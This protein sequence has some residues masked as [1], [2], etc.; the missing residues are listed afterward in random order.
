MHAMIRDMSGAPEQPVRPRGGLLGVLPYLLDLIFPIVA[1]FV[2]KKLGASDFWALTAGGLLTLAVTVVNTIRRA[3]V[4]SIGLLVLL[5]LALSVVLTFAVRD[6]RLILARPSLYIAVAALWILG[7][8]FTG[9]PPTVDTSKPMAYK[10]DPRRLVAYEWAAEHSPAFL[11]I[12]RVV[13][14]IWCVTFLVYAG[15]R[16]VIIYT[17]DDIG[18]TVWLNEIPGVI[19]IAICLFAA[20]RAGGRLEKIVDERVE[21]MFPVSK[22]AN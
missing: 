17:V 1:F 3:K 2:L 10:G 13:S 4:D 22:A 12:H 15:L 7:K 20:A 18:E 14:S 16:L 21:Q 6:P 5:E 11:R 8:T 9:R 19:G